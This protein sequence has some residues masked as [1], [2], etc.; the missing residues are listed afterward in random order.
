[1][2]GGHPFGP[3]N[4]EP[5]FG[6]L[7][8]S[9]LSSSNWPDRPFDNALRDLLPSQALIRKYLHDPEFHAV[10]FQAAHLLLAKNDAELARDRAVSELAD[11]RSE[12]AALRARIRAALIELPEL[13]PG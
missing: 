11:L 4:G 9:G 3:F 2:S 8:P 10:A 13:A 5:D 1:M 7:T 6:P 12:H